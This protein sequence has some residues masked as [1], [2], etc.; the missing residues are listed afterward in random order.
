M[1]SGAGAG[2]EDCGAAVVILGCEICGDFRGHFFGKGFG[3]EGHYG[4]TEAATCEACTY[5]VRAGLQEVNESIQLGDTVFKEKSGTLVRCEKEGA[6]CFDVSAHE[7][8][9]AV[10]DALIFLNDVACPCL[11]FWREIIL[12]FAELLGG[13]VGK[14]LDIREELTEDAE[15]FHA[16]LMARGVK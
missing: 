9:Y 7:G 14:A 6:D 3:G 10:F 16:L 11:D 13:D 2:A 8:H 12:V 5:D 1:S 15:G 4:A